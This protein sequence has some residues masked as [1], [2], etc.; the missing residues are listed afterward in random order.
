VRPRFGSESRLGRWKILDVVATT[1]A[2]QVL[3]SAG[4]TEEKSLNPSVNI[5]FIDGSS[6]TG[7]YNH[8]FERI[9]QVFNVT[10]VSDKGSHISL[11]VPVG[12]YRT[13]RASISYNSDRS[14]PFS[15][16]G[17][18][19]WGDYY[20][21]IRN[22]ISLGARYHYN[23]RLG[24]SFT[25]TRN[26]VDLPQGKLHTDQT[27]LTVDYR[28]NPKMSLRSFIQYNNQSDQLSSN[29]RFRLIHH[30]LSDIFLVYNELRDR[31]KQK[32]DWGLSLKYTRLI[33]F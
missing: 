9:V 12:D 1:S 29:I 25:Y 11:G 26:S 23:Y 7:N 28:F 27:A 16:N 21:G 18:Y 5:T 33:S 17:S 10:G 3:F 20:G 2:E 31:A 6:L 22:S 8:N 4:G 13:D 19:N 14:K 15:G 32:T 24:L 30:P